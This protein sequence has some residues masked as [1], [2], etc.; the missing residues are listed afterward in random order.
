[1]REATVIPFGGGE[2][3]GDAPDRRVEILC[4]H[5]GL[6]ATWTRFGPGR[7]GA[8]PHIHREHTDLF[9]VLAGE[10]TVRLGAEDRITAAPA[11]TLVRVPPLV[12]HGFRNAGDTEL[13]YLNLHAPGRGFADYM[14]GLRDKQPVD[15]DQEDPPPDG[16][17]PSAEAVVGADG[18]IAEADG[19]RLALL[20][21][22]E[23]IGIAEVRAEPGAPAPS[24]VHPGHAES[25]YVLEGEIALAAGGRELRAGAG[26]WAQVPPGAEHAVSVPGP[27]PARVLELHAPSRGFG[28]YVR[29][30]AG[31]AGEGEAA[32]GFDHRPAS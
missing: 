1:M 12:V 4:E 24:H 22:V 18:A 15:F 17:R 8:S 28:S 16:V 26:A 9:Y 7:E 32:E 10:L 11:G 20:A 23:A 19:R 29:A 13:R 3:I 2:I 6:H 25:L 5:D 30:L 31:G 27:H 14:R 21:D